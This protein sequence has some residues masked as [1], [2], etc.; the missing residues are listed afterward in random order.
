M[1]VNST[2]KEVQHS[3]Q[4]QE[5]RKAVK[6]CHTFDDVGTFGVRVNRLS[7]FAINTFKPVASQQESSFGRACYVR[8]HHGALTGVNLKTYSRHSGLRT[9][10]RT[11]V[12]RLLFSATY[13]KST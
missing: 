4:R 7:I 11:P 9:E 3:Q 13:R 10:M 2:D 6:H 1:V 8:D 5:P 12:S